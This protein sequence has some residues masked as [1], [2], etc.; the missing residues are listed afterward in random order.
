MLPRLERD[1]LPPGL[2]TAVVRQLGA[3]AAAGVR[4]CVSAGE[5]LPAPATRTR[6]STSPAAASA[7]P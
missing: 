6:F 1:E 4:L 7:T 3:I 5:A 2:T